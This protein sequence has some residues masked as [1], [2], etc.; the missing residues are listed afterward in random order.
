MAVAG[1]DI[2]TTGAKCTVFDDSGNVRGY[3]YS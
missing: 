1:V 2:G 3:A